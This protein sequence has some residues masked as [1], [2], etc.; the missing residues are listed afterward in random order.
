MKIILFLL[1][2][3]SLT[4]HAEMLLL[5]E[6]VQSVN[7]DVG[8]NVIL[9]FNDI[10]AAS[11]NFNGYSSLSQASWDATDLFVIYDQSSSLVKKTTVADFDGR[12]ELQTNKATDFSVLNDILYPSVDAVYDWVMGVLSEYV[13][14]IPSGVT[15][16]AANKVDFT[17]S[18]DG[19]Q[20]QT[21]KTAAFASGSYNGGGTGSKGFVSFWNYDLMPLSSLTNLEFSVKNLYDELGSSLAGNIYWNIL[22]NFN[23]GYTTLANDYVNIVIDGLSEHKAIPLR[24]Y[25]PSQ[26]SYTTYTHNASALANE[27]MVKCVGG[28]EGVTNIINSGGT[29]VASLTGTF[30]SGSP[31]VTGLSLTDS[32]TVGQYIA[33]ATNGEYP[34]SSKVP[35]GAKILSID[36]STQITMDVNA[37][38]T[39]GTQTIMFYGGIAPADRVGTANGTTTI[40]VANTDDLIVN[41]GVTCA[42]CPA[43]SYIVSKV[44]DVSITLNNS[45]PIGSPTLSFLPLGKTGCPGNATNI[46][47]TWAKLVANNPNAYFVNTTPTVA[48]GWGA[49]DG[50]W[51]AN[52]KYGA[53]NLVMNGSTT[54]QARNNLIKNATINSD[55][56][57]FFLY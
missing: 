24:Y 4:V 41:M 7:G 26:S 15:V 13:G 25:N 17:L 47:I 12:Y 37:Q 49:A 2:L 32:L 44:R 6:G 14:G 11:D 38:G 50:G 1:T 3:I 27:R 31:I 5:G 10:G 23:T 45:V 39:N 40:T 33:D 43:G 19:L 20:M 29:A 57:K 48:G 35:A 9:D 34:A 54:L 28:I 53:F 18:K 46:G 16:S 42:S 8:P 36:S 52:A 21:Y 22:A 30:T 56:Y 51:V 55:I